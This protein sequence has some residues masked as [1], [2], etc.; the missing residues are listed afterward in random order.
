MESSA[1]EGFWRWITGEVDAGAMGTKARRSGVDRRD[2]RRAGEEKDQ[3]AASGSVLRGAA[4]SGAWMGGRRVLAERKREREREGALGAVA[5]RWCG[6]GPAAARVG[7]ALPRDS[8]ERRGRR[9]AVD[10]TDRWAGT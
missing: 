10:V 2:K 4:G 9:D 1:E 8:G 7:G 3:M 6:S 5:C